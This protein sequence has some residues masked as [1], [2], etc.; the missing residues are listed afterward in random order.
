MNELW[1]VAEAYLCTRPG[2][3]IGEGSA[4]VAV[5]DSRLKRP[6]R[7]PMRDYGGKCSPIAAEYCY[8]L[9]IAVP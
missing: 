3:G 9:E 7:K 4:T 6:W 1:K 5:E 8:I 2:E